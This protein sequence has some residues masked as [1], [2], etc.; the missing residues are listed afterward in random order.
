MRWPCAARR[1]SCQGRAAGGRG[2][3]RGGGGKPTPPAHACVYIQYMWGGAPQTFLA[4]PMGVACGWGG[5]APKVAGSRENNKKKGEKNR[6][7]CTVLKFSL[8][9]YGTYIPLVLSKKAMQL[10]Q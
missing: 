1:L 7:K 6:T 8:Y 5:R 2:R 4:K 9:N 10:L 3:G